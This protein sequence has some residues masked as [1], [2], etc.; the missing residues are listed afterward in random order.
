[1]NIN[2]LNELI[3]LSNQT[4]TF[5]IEYADGKYGKVGKE[6]NITR[7]VVERFMEISTKSD[8]EEV[9]SYLEFKDEMIADNGGAGDLEDYINYVVNIKPNI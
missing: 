2:K 5:L 1:M 7:E 4:E 6:I 8:M 9:I 3:E